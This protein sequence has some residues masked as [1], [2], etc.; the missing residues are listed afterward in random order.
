MNDE[1]YIL[2]QR[3]IFMRC[4]MKCNI[5]NEIIEFNKLCADISEY[6]DCELTY[7]VIKGIIELVK[8][9][10]KETEDEVEL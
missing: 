4:K 1:E 6:K 10:K 3:K 2:I 9:Y 8:K 5:V 7:S